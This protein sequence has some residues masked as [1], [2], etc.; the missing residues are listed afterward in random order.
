MTRRNVSQQKEQQ[1][2][3][4]RTM[5]QSE[6]DE[7]MQQNQDAVENNNELITN[8]AGDTLV[9]PAK[10]KISKDDSFKTCKAEM[11]T[12]GAARRQLR[13]TPARNSILSGHQPFKEVSSSGKKFNRRRKV[14]KSGQ[15][16][17]KLNDTAGSHET[18][19][20]HEQE[21]LFDRDSLDTHPPS[22]RRMRISSTPKPCF[23][24][25]Q[26]SVTRQ[27]S[28]VLEQSE[29]KPAPPKPRVVQSRIKAARPKPNLIPDSKFKAP[30]PQAREFNRFVTPRTSNFSTRYCD[31]A[32]SSIFK[33]PNMAPTGALTRTQS[34]K[35]TAELERDYFMSLR[36]RV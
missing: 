14:N 21:L 12:G 24:R 22:A 23:E 7:Q 9:T 15:N 36:S 6:P 16:L 18:F 19:V 4:T 30:R 35:S 25:I 2:D 1:L 29:I 8:E 26:P 27:K 20:A 32:K 13:M 31:S 11:P 33:R 10:Q 3:A 5:Q 34:F 28:P 17:S